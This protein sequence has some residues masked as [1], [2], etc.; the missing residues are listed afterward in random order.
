M[1]TDH[2]PLGAGLRR[3][4][5][6]PRAR[7]LRDA[8]LNTTE[9]DVRTLTDATMRDV[10][11]PDPLVAPSLSQFGAQVLTEFVAMRRRTTSSR[12]FSRP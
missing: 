4:N 10:Q 7:W 3:S 1:H 12:D 6:T 9:R 2:L 11:V 8:A 5:S